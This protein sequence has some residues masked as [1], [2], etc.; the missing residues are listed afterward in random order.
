M[1][2]PTV[3]ER[4]YLSPWEDG[5]ARP[6]NNPDG[7]A[8]QTDSTQDTENRDNHLQNS[9]TEMEPIDDFLVN[10]KKWDTA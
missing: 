6:R 2:A 7:L 1:N 4:V 3:E 5:T 10:S 9:A 8:A